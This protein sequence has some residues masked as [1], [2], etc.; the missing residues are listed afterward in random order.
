MNIRQVG[1]SGRQNTLAGR[2]LDT[3]MNKNMNIDMYKVR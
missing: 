1:H 2:A 3:K